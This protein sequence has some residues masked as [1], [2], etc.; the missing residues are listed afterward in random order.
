MSLSLFRSVLALTFQRAYFVDLLT[1]FITDAKFARWEF[2]EYVSPL[3]EGESEA[4]ARDHATQAVEL[5]H[6]LAFR[7]GLGKS[8]FA[9]AHSNLTVEDVKAYAATAF[10]KGNVAV[11]GTGI[12]QETLSS[13][14]DKAFAK[15]AEGTAASSP[16]SAYYG[17]ETRVASHAGP[18]TVFVGFGTTGANSAE[19]AALA[20][21][22]SPSTIKWSK[23]LSPLAELP[24]ETSVQPVYLPYT[25]ATLFGLLVQGSTAEG[26]KAAA[27]KAVAALK[28]SAQGLKAEE[29]KSAVAKAKFAAAAASETRE[30]LVSTLG[31]KVGFDPFA[32]CIM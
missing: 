1:S 30:G 31:S 19:L 20:A 27:T 13:L 16:A 2:E 25:D 3:V 7:N 11:I 8:L 21:H 26:V 5:A 14:V 23:G 12:S 18:Q 9:P 22:L 28:Q 32:L 6:A 4:L 10:S 24:E 15:A 17:G 29:V